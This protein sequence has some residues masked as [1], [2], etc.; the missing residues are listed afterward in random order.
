[1]NLQEQLPS[2]SGI[3]EKPADSPD[4]AERPE[5]LRSSD[6]LKGKREVWIEH[7]SDMYRL[8]VT[9]SGKLYLTK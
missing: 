4:D 8:R 1:M 6:L 7:R 3:L 5:I 9:S 2:D